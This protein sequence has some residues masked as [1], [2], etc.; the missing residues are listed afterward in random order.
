M[1]LMQTKEQA[2]NKNLEIPLVDSYALQMGPLPARR[3]GCK[4]AESNQ[5]YNYSNLF[6]MVLSSK[7]VFEFVWLY[8]ELEQA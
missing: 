1:K 6:E 5:T 3:T 4:W 2:V 8:I 7:F